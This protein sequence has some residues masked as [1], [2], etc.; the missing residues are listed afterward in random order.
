MEL[1]A[2]VTQARFAD[3]RLYAS[4]MHESMTQQLLSCNEKVQLECNAKATTG[5]VSL[6]AFTVFAV[7]YVTQ[8]SIQDIH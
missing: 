8:A 5:A 3:S 6:K 2:E 7:A 4:P 1:L